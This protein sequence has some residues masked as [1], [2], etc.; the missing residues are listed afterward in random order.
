MVDIPTSSN[1]EDYLILAQRVELLVAS[2]VSGTVGDD[3]LATMKKLDLEIT[4]P[5]TRINHGLKRTYG[6][7]SPDIGLRFTLSVTQDVLLYLRTR[8]LRSANGV[9]PE[10]V[11]A[12][13]VTANNNTSKTITV[14]GKLTEKKY[15]KEDTEQGETVNVDC[16]IRVTDDAEPAAT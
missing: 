1:L 9:I 3:K 7:G 13:K 14:K 15:V 16:L 10:Y 12:M 4:H 2:A 8:G 6:H 5:E 11:W